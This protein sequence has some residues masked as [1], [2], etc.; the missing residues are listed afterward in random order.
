M[1]TTT[2][3]TLPPEATKADFG[4]ALTAAR[5]AA[6]LKQYELAAALGLCARTLMRWEGGVAMPR[7]DVRDKIVAWLRS[8]TG[9]EADRAL[10]ALG[11]R[12]VRTSAA[13][14]PIAPLSAEAARAA[15]V[16]IEHA[17]YKAAE[18]NDA[19]A[20]VARQIALGVLAAIEAAGVTV[21]TARALL[22]VEAKT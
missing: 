13:P 12:F 16:A 18:A 5:K 8:R 22:A 9:R 17:L 20:R 3:A 14:L 11:V 6:G 1:T 4:A 15:K 7:V 19:P 21:A 2:G 10:E